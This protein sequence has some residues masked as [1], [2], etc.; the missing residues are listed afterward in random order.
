MSLNELSIGLLELDSPRGAQAA[1]V[2]PL[3]GA[4]NVKSSQPGMLAYGRKKREAR[5]VFLAA[6]EFEPD[7]PFAPAA[8]PNS[9]R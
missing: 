6:L 2:R 3:L 5:R 1:G 7:D 4:R 8:W 9:S